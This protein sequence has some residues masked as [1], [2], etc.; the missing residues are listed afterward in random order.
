MKDPLWTESASLTDL[1]SEQA[2][3]T[4]TWTAA[5]A[6]TDGW[7]AS[8]VPFSALTTLIEGDDDILVIGDDGEY[9]KE[10]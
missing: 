10:D 5:A 4:K 2:W 1:W 3:V 9:I 7:T 6:L 8:D